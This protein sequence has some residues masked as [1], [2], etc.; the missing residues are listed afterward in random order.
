MYVNLVGKFGTKS[1]QYECI[2]KLALVNQDQALTIQDL[3]KRGRL[4]VTNKNPQ[5]LYQLLLDA[6]ADKG[7]TRNSHLI[8]RNIYHCTF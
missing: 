4:F 2:V 5:V 7:N 1:E 3:A 8:L 6:E